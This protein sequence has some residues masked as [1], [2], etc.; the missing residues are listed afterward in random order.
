ML[1]TLKR[2]IEKLEDEVLPQ[3]FREIQIINHIPG[4]LMEKYGREFTIRVPI[5]EKRQ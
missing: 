2:R 4:V 1:K 3:K 5:K